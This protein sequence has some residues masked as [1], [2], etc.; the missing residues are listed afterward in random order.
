MTIARRLLRLRSAAALAAL[1]AVALS[2]GGSARA[3]GGQ[4]PS[5][6]LLN[7]GSAPI[8]ELYVTPAGDARW[9]QNRLQ[10]RAIQPGGSYPVRRRIDGNCIFDIRVVFAG[11]RIL[12]RRNLNTCTTDDV[13][14]GEAAAGS[15]P[16]AKAAGDPSFRL[17]NHA[18]QPII[19]AFATPAGFGNWGQNRLTAGP[20][21]PQGERPLRIDRQPN[22]CLFDL[23]VVF[24]DHT[25]RE[26]RRADLCRITSL[27]VQ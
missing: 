8:R 12:D 26:K 2:Q 25:A 10:G 16:A 20:I 9:G 1:L 11:G 23:R 27:P 17:V 5:F 15:P 21:P 3:Q 13:A 18:A 24:A 7:H 14:V 4:N 22:S 6:N 19:Q